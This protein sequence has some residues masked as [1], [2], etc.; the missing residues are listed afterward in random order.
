MIPTEIEDRHKKNTNFSSN[1]N[2]LLS[3]NPI[4][5]KKKKIHSLLQK[6]MLTPCKDIKP[7]GGQ[8]KS[9]CG[10]I[11]GH[12]YVCVDKMLEDIKN[13]RVR[14]K[15]IKITLLVTT[16]LIVSFLN[17]FFIYSH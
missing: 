1:L 11:D 16:H 5:L 13:N 7:L 12:K 17:D 9:F 14:N 4:K 3:E 8:Y 6:R 10:A 15:N 2:E